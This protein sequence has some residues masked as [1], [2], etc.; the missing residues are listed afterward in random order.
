MNRHLWAWLALL[1]LCWV[2]FCNAAVFERDWTSPGDGL[3]TFDDVNQRE[4]LDMSVSRL[5]QFSGA[6]L[7]DRYQNAITEI[8][9][10]G[11]FDG[12]MVA[13]RVDVVELAESAGVNT[14]TDD[15]GTNQAAVGKLIDLIGPTLIFRSEQ[16]FS[17]GFLDEPLMGFSNRLHSRFALVAADPTFA[18]RASL[19]FFTPMDSDVTAPS[20]YGIMLF[21]QVPEPSSLS[22]AVAG[23]VSLYGI[24]VRRGAR[25]GWSGWHSTSSSS[26]I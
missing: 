11:L 15:F 25:Y 13:K 4:W 21:R 8:A 9:P 23:I 18:G 12:F 22:L 2:N 20:V 6:R 5:N 7:E 3:L 17:L 1:M 16:L 26:S 24:H 19:E 14:T 10:G